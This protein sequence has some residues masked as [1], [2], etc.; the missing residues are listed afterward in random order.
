MLGPI[1]FY[2]TYILF[3]FNTWRKI[4]NIW[5][6]LIVVVSNLLLN[7]CCAIIHANRLLLQILV[8]VMYIDKFR[9]RRGGGDVP[10]EHQNAPPDLYDAVVFAY[11]TF[12]ISLQSSVMSL[13]TEL[14]TSLPSC[15]HSHY[16]IEKC[17][18]SSLVDDFWKL[19]SW[20][21]LIDA[22]C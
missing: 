5:I 9:R 1:I 21:L 17:M 11:N 20:H 10:Q 4:L 8:W 7:I 12:V 16:A 3:F 19:I 2:I 6:E 14:Q 13:P 18:T 15:Y 22:K